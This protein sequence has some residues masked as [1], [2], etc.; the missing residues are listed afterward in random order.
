MEDLKPAGQA[1]FEPM[2]II[3][4]TEEP[5]YTAQHRR[6]EMEE[7]IIDK[8]ALELHRK[9]VIRRAWTSGYNSPMM[10]VKKKDGRWRSVIDYRR[11][12]SLTIK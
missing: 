12:N 11:I 4:R 8:E 5:V 7:E 3:L 1:F 10:V 9:G 2:K 6:S